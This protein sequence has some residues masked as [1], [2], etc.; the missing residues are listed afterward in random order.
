[1]DSAQNELADKSVD[2]N[3]NVAYLSPTSCLNTKFWQP[4]YKMFKLTLN[5]RPPANRPFEP[6]RSNPHINVP[7]FAPAWATASQKRL[8][9]K[10]TH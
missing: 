10:L 9:I 5:P 1:M 8:S 3:L 7:D 2:R 6:S 4:L